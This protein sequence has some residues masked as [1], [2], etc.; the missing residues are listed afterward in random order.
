MITSVTAQLHMRIY[1]LKM[2]SSSSTASSELTLTKKPK[3]VSI[4]WDYFGLKADNEG[5]V[6]TEKESLPVC[7]VCLKEVPA[8]SGNTSNMLVHL[9]EHHPNKYSE[10]H[11]KVAKKGIKAKGDGQVQPTLQQTYERATKYPP[12][13]PT[14]VELNSAVTYFIAKDMRPVSIVEKPGFQHMVSKL[15]PRYQLHSRKHFSDYEVPKLCLSTSPLYEDHTGRNIAAALK[16][17][18]ENW[19]L[20]AENLIATTKSP[21]KSSTI[22]YCIDYY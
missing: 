11:P 18:L 6:L 15:N 21:L 13:S 12:Q 3:A 7:R 19:G 9:R 2:G 10:A 20:S 4:V 1:Y 22:I 17:I 8:K 14:A 16:D 5:R